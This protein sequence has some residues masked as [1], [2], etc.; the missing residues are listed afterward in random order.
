VIDAK[1]FMRQIDH[2]RRVLVGQVDVVQAN[3]NRRR[4][5]LAMVI[6]NAD[7]TNVVPFR[8]QQFDHHSPIFAKP[9][10][11]R[12][13]NHSFGNLGPTRRLQAMAAFHFHQAHAAP[14]VRRDSFHVTER[15]NFASSMTGG[16]KD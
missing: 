2:S 3:L 12:S 1:T 15:R 7:R 8:K 10:R 14:T 5:Q 4:L 16:L 13:H 9:L 11:I 6:R